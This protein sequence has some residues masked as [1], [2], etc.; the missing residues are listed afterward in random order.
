MRITL[1]VRSERLVYVSTPKFDAEDILDT[2]LGV[3][4]AGLNTQIAAIEAEKIAA[5][6]G[7]TPTLAQIDSGSYVEQTWSDEILNFNPGIFYGIED[8]STQSIGM[9]VAKTYKIFCE[10]IVID[11]GNS[12]GCHKRIL[13]YSRALEE[14][15]ETAFKDAIG[16]GKASVEQV[17]PISFKKDL[18]S[19][20]EIKIGG[21][22][23]TITLV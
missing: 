15:F 13:R 10:V 19:S 16:G 9:A 17:R 12:V 5:G 7:L 6:K 11:D 21:I 2:V 22:S 23:L 18:D 3:M 14:I 20:E 8:V 4:T 1:L